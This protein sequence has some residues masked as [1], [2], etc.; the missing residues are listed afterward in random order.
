MARVE[1]KRG[2]LVAAIE[3]E[4]FFHELAPDLPISPTIELATRGA[5][6]GAPPF[7]SWPASGHLAIPGLV[8]PD[9][10][11]RMANAI[12]ALVY[13]GVPALFAYVYDAF[14]MPLGP[15]L[16]ALEPLVG[17]CHALRDVWA[18]LV[19]I[20]DQHGGWKPHRGTY[21]VERTSSGAPGTINVWIALTDTTPDNACMH[22][23]PLDRD[24]AYPSRLDDVSVDPQLAAPLP[25][26]AGTAL[27]WDS[28]LL[29]W[30]GRSSARA[31]AP[32]ISF[33][34]T[35]RA[36]E[37]PSP[38]T[39]PVDFEH[40]SFRARLDLIAQMIGIYGENE[41]PPEPIRTWARMLALLDVAR[42]ER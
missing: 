10:A 39:E 17:R 7:A 29:H 41:P 16:A 9:E 25:A 1:W 33:S 20:G 34:Y 4:A 11:R 42:K 27:A 40:L 3:N 14:W 19:P 8:A 35:L 6:P 32:R 2:G 18:W 31:R 13:A 23:V 24:V 22:A 5:V 15:L 37:L 21:V 38:G 28:N 26:A 36:S 12:R 30:G